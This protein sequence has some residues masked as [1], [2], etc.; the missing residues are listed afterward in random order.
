[1]RPI[2]IVVVLLA[3]HAAHAGS[4]P[5]PEIDP[6]PL[7]EDLAQKAAK[8]L[9]GILGGVGSVVDPQKVKDNARAGCLKAQEASRK[10]ARSMWDKAP[11]ALRSTCQAK[12]A[13]YVE[14]GLCLGQGH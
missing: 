2:V 12:A 5:F 6:G 9:Q 11:D 14:L 4:V 7:C 1:M 8:G 13:N 3:A 10:Q